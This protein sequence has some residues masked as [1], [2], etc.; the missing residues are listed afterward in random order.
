MN[1]VVCEDAS[2][3][4]VVNVTPQIAFP[5]LNAVGVS[6]TASATGVVSDTLT[7]C[8]GEEVTFTASGG[9]S[10]RFL[11]GGV[12]VQAR[13]TA[14][15][16]ST[17]LLLIND[18]VT[19]E[20]FD[21]VTG[22]CLTETEEII[23]DYSPTPLVGLTS[24][25]IADTFC[26]DDDILFTANS[27]IPNSTYD[28]Y[29]DGFRVF[30]PSTTSTFTAVAGTVEDLDDVSVI[31]TSPAGCSATASLTM[32]ENEI[33]SVGTLTTISPTIC[34]GDVS[35]R[36]VGT[37]ASASGSITY[38]WMNSADNVTYT[39]ITGTNSVSYDPGT[40]TNT[41][42]FKRKT[43]S[44]L[45]GIVCE[46]LSTAIRIDVTATPSATI[47]AN[48]GGI[49]GTNT[50]TIC[51]GAEIVFTG[52]GGVEYEFTID[53]ITQQ[54]RSAQ[55][56]YTTSGLLNNELVQVIAYGATG[57]SNVSDGIRVDI[58]PV[59]VVNLSSDATGNTFC[60]GDVVNFTAISNLPSSTFTFSIGGVPRQT[61][62]TPTF[63]PTDYV[64][65]LNHNDVVQVDVTSMDG[66]TTVASI[67]L[68]ENFINTAG[69]IGAV[70][71]TICAG[72][73]PSAITNTASAVASGTI[74]YQWESGIDTITFTPITGA[75]AATY[76]PT[77][78][79]Q[80]TY[81][82][83]VAISTLNGAICED[84]TLPF[85]IIV[86]PPI[87]GGTVSPTSE[88][89]CSG[90]T[91]SLLTVVGGSTG[92]LLTYQWQ[93]STDGINYTNLATATSA[94]FQPPALN[95]TR[96]YKRITNAVGGGGAASCNDESTAIRITVLDID[97]GALDPDLDQDYCYGILP[98]SLTSSLTGGVIDDAS[99]SNGTVTYVWESSTNNI[100]WTTIATATNNFYNPPA[101]TETT[102][103]RRRAYATLGGNTCEDVTDAIRIGVLPKLDNGAVL[104]DQ[105]ICQIISAAELPD[106][107][108][109]DGAETLSASLSYQW[110]ISND[111]SSWEDIAGQQSETLDFSLGDT[112]LPTVPA[113]YYRA[114]VTYVGDPAPAAI[115][116]T[117]IELLPTAFPLTAGQE[118]SVA[119]NGNNYT[120]TTVTASTIDTVGN[121][122]A[123]SITNND[124]VVNATYN[125]AN[126][127]LTIVP[128]VPGT[129]NVA[130]STGTPDVTLAALI[131]FTTP[132]ID[133]QVLVSGDNGARTPNPNRASCQIYSEVI[134][135]EVFE[136]P[137]L[138]Q[139][140]GD[141]SPQEVCAG[142]TIDP[143]TYVI[144]GGA[145][146]A[147]IRG[148]DA[149]L[150]VTPSGTGTV[151]PDPAI[152]G[153]YEVSGTTTFTISGTVGQTTN[154]NVVTLGS[155]PDCTEINE[156][157]LIRVSPLAQTPDFIRKDVNQPGYEVLQDPGNANIW[158]NN[159][160]CQDR[161]P[162]P[163][164][165]P[166]E[167][168][169]CFVDNTFNQQFVEF[170]WD[171]SPSGAGSMV[172]NNFQETRVEVT[173][174]LTAAA[175][176][177]YTA[178]LTTA[179]GTAVYTVTTTAATN[180]NDAIGQALADLINANAAVSARYDNTNPT[181][182]I[183]VE[184]VT[185]NTP[186]TL[187]VA[188]TAAG[189]SSMFENPITRQITRSG[190]MNWD[191]FFSGEATIR[192]RSLG[193]S[194][195]SAWRDIIVDVVPESVPAV[196]PSDLYPPV[197][198]DT[199]ICSGDTTGPI[200]VC[201]ITAATPDTQF[202]AASNNAGNVNDYESLEWNIS[203][204]QPGVGSL[205]N[206]PG[207]INQ[208]TGIM[209][210]TDGWYGN[211]ELQV[212]PISCTGIVGEWSTITITIGAEDGPILS[213][214]ADQLP[215]CPIPA[216]GFTTVLTTGGESVRWFVNSTN[217]LAT[218]T[219]YVDTPT[220]ELFSPDPDQLTL[221]FR[222][223][224]SGAVI[225]TA[226]PT[227][228]PGNSVNYVIQVP[229][230][231]TITLTSGF[232]SN[233]QPNI[234]EGGSILPITYSIEGA[235]N[236][237]FA[238][239][240]PAGIISFLEV[241]TQISTLTLSTNAAN[242]PAGGRNYAIAINNTN[243][244]YT[245]TG[246]NTLND[247]GIGLRDA[248][249]TATDDFEATWSNPNLM[250]EV[251]PTGR[252]SDSFIIS[253][254]V[255]LTNSVNISA[256]ITAPLE[257]TFTISGTLASTVTPGTYSFDVLT[258]PA[259]TGC[260]SATPSSGSI[261]VSGAAS[262][263]VTGTTNMINSQAICNGANYTNIAPLIEFAITD[264]ANI[265]ESALNPVSL[266]DLGLA[267]NITG[268][269]QFNIVGTVNR[270]VAVATVYS[271][272]L[273]ANGG[274][275]ADE[276][277]NLQIEVQPTPTIT[278]ND[279]LLAN[280]TVCVSETITP[281]RFEVLQP[282]F[283][284]TAT[285][286]A[287]P[288]G[289]TGQMYTQNQIVSFEVIGALPASTSQPSETFTININNT[290][291][292]YTATNTRLND[293]IAAD[294][295]NFLNPLLVG[296]YNVTNAPGS[297][298][299]QI[300]S[301]NPGVAYNVLVS[302]IS[303]DLNLDNVTVVRPPGFYEITGT[304][305]VTINTPQAYTYTLFSSGP[306]CSG[307]ATYSG[308]ITVN[309]I[310]YGIVSGGTGAFGFDEATQTLPLCDSN[311]APNF[312]QYEVYGGALN[313]NVV[314]PTTPSWVTTTFTPGTPGILT[315]SVPNPP[316][317][318][319]TTTQ[320]FNYEIGLIGNIYG[321]TVTPNTVRGTIVVTADDMISH[322]GTSGA[323]IQT[324][325]VNST[326]SPT[327]AL[328]PIEY[329]LDGGA[330]GAYT[331]ISVDGGTTW[332]PG[333]PPGLSLNLTVSNTMLISGVAT[334][335]ATT[336]ASPT[337]VYDYRIITTPAACVSATSSGRITVL[338]QP[339]LSLVS[340]ATSD[341]QTGANG[342]CDGTPIQEIRYRMGGGATNV[343]FTWTGPGSNTLFGSGITA[344]ASGTDFIIS[345]TPTVNV[346]Q[347]TTYNY[348]IETVG[349]SCSPEIVLN[350]T[351]EIKPD[352]T[353]TLIS[354][355][356]TDNQSIC[357]FDDDNTGN[358]T[359]EP[360]IDIEYQLGGGATNATVVGLPAGIGFSLT[361]SNT[362][363]IS[364][365]V[366]ASTTYTAT[367]T[368][369]YPYTITTNGD[370]TVAILNGT[371]TVHSPPVMYLDS[372]AVTANQIGSD[373]V[374]DRV[375]PIQ[376]II[377]QLAGGATNATVSW[378]GVNGVLTGVSAS[379]S[380][381]QIVLSGTPSVNVTQTTF[382][383]Y[384]IVTNNS[385]CLPEVT[386][387]GVIQV[388][389]QDIITLISTPTSDNQEICLFDQDNPGN[390][391][392]EP[393]IDIEYQLDG[394]ATN[395]VVT[396]LPAGIGYSLTA[397][398]TILISGTV[399]AS[400][401]YTA[402]PTRVYPYVITTNGSC[403]QAIANGTI[404]VRSLPVLTL[405]SSPSTTNQTAGD[406]VCN[407]IEPIQNI[408]YTFSGG[409][410]GVSLS[411]VATPGILPGVSGAASG[412]Q[413]VIS[414]TPSANI[415]STTTYYYE[416]A[417]NNSACAPEVV[418][419]GSIE[420][421][422]ADR[423]TLVSS[424]TTDA[425]QICV[426]TGTGTLENI[427]YNL[428]N[429]ATGATVV[430]L[431]PGVGYTVF[432]GQVIISGTV[433]ASASLSSATI[434]P[435]AY[436][437]ETIGCNPAIETGTIDVIPAPEMYLRSGNPNAA[438]I[439]NGDIIS[440]IEYVFNPASGGIPVI[441]WDVT[442]TSFGVPT[443]ASTGG[444]VN[445]L[446]VL[447][448]LT[449]NETIS[450]TTIYNYTVRL[451]G[452][453]DSPVVMSG[454]ITISPVPTIDSQFIIDNDV[455]DVTCNGGIDGSIV[456]PD[457]TTVQFEQRIYGGLLSIQQVDE[458]TFSG[459]PTLGDIVTVGVGGN[460]YSHTVVPTTYGSLNPQTIPQIVSDLAVTIN[461]AIGANVSAA[462][463]VPAT[464]ILRLRADVGGIAL[465]TDL[466]AIPVTTTAL[467]A[468]V[469]TVV[470]NR[471]LN[472]S[473]SWT[474]PNGFTSSSLSIYNLEAGDYYLT[475]DLNGCAETS[476]PITVS[477]P[478]TIVVD[479][480][481]CGGTT[482][483]FEANITGGVPPYSLILEDD[484][485][486]QVGPAI[487][488]NGGQVYS[489]LAVGDDYI[490][491]VLDSSC[492]VAV[493]EPIRIPTQLQFIH[494]DTANQGVTNS[495]CS[496]GTIGNGSIELTRSVG[497][498]FESAFQGGSNQFSYVWTSSSSSG[499]IGSTPN[500]YNL[501]PD[502][503]T[504]TVTDLVLGCSD[505]RQFTVG[506]FP[507][508][509]LE[510]V[511]V[512]GLQENI[513]G[514]S[515]TTISTFTGTATTSTADYVYYLECN[516]DSDAAFT[517]RATGGNS[518][519]T[520]TSEVPT[521]TT[522]S[523][524]G[525]SISIQ[526]GGPGFYRFTLDDVGPNG[527]TC[528]DF[529]TVQVIEPS[530]M[531]I[532]EVQA[533]RVDP[534]CFGE[535]G[536][537]VFDVNGGSPNRGPYTI[538]LNGGQL[539]GTSSSAGDRRIIITG[540][541]TSLYNIIA[542]E[543]F[544][545]D[546]YGCSTPSNISTITFSAAPE[547][548][549]FTTETVDIDCAADTEGSV[550]FERI[551][552]GDF[553]DPNLIQIHIYRDNIDFDLYRNWGADPTFKTIDG[554]TQPG[555][556]SYDILDEQN[557]ELIVG[558][559][560]VIRVVGN[561]DP[562]FVRSIDVEQVGCENDT[563]KIRLNIENIQPPLDIRWFQYTYLTTTTSTAS[564]TTNTT[565]DGWV[566]LTGLN[567]FATVVGLDEGVYRAEISDG[568][569]EN[570]GGA[571][572]TNSIILEE[573]SIEITNFRTIENN[574]AFCDNYSSNFTSD[575]LFSI[576]ESLNRNLG[577][578]SFNITLLTESGS[579][580]NNPTSWD[581]DNDGFI[582]P[583]P[584]GYVYRYPELPADRY[585]LIVEE[586][587]PATLPATSTLVPCS[588]VFFFEIQDY[589]PIE[590]VGQTI[591]ETDICT[592]R[593]E[594]IEG[595][596][597]GGVP[598]II[599][600][601]PT[602]Q[603]EWTYTPNDPTQSPTKFFGRVIENAPPGTY[604]VKI[605]DSNGCFY[606][607]CDINASSEPLDIIVED[608]VTPFTVTAALPNP[609][610]PTELV[611][612][613]SPNCDSGGLDGQIGI[614]L[615]GGLL[616]YQ[617]TWYVEDPT[618]VTPNAIVDPNDPSSRL[619][620][621]RE[622]PN[623][624]N[625]T[626]L[627]GLIPGNY[628]LVITSQ[629]PRVT[630]CAQQNNFLNNNYL[631][632]E[633]IIQVSPNREL[634]IM[635]G[636][637]VD[638]DLCT[639]QQGRLI[640]D[641]FDNNNG[642]LS[643]YYNDILIPNS[644]VVRLSDRSWSVAIVN[645]VDSANFK[646]VNEEGCWITTEINRG[647]GDP[648]FN[649]TSPNF[650][651]SSVILARE[652]ITF[653]NTST[654]PYVTSEWIFGDNTP[655]EIVPTLTDSIIPVRHTYGVSGT[656]F[657]TLRIYNDIGCSEEITKPISVGKGY[658]IMVP[659]VFT[660]NNDLVNDNFRPLFSGFANMTFTVYDYRGNVVY[661]EYVEE[662]DL[663]N[664]QGI[665]ITG[666]DA[667]NAPFSPY[668]IY[669]AY[670][671]LLDGETE[672]EK[673]GTFILIN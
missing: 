315:I 350:G 307:S 51:D 108:T 80:T 272:D 140:N 160:V 209:D 59:P 586:R 47:T 421:R 72:D 270:P 399:A 486:V 320:T 273:I 2:N 78:L 212:R 255:P 613:I 637:Y 364:G 262:I 489:G 412:T 343:G 328:D 151:T 196:D 461:N 545:S 372:P 600:G 516:G 246:S 148:L 673:S 508:L 352:D 632:Y 373:A 128:V 515:T 591:I 17:T 1:S 418:L 96:F 191:P 408:V 393:F 21:A 111:Q 119:I 226:E 172:D 641:I 223:G 580:I 402:S 158:Y 672:I 381:T 390:T 512:G 389:P 321:C 536:T 261:T 599:D 178:S 13:G 122:L 249:N 205:V 316:S 556:Y 63:T 387:S 163:T 41:T 594:R 106:P 85:E 623:Y 12:E 574:P 101:L 663:T 407:Q 33:T 666:W 348:Q 23:I 467:T 331:E 279:P 419:T 360:F 497:G 176:E 14:N 113:T 557:C 162:A 579:A 236:G 245:T 585:T 569:S 11:V 345:G 509:N 243:Y 667:T 30:G 303:A 190:T 355:P 440:P 193:C 519:Y 583:K 403:V 267:L 200:P 368:Q 180:T 426:G 164:T 152:N 478:D 369:V 669:T 626:Y 609:D 404:T 57:C 619:L 452:T 468:T 89:I 665:S 117:S 188:P 535:L 93:E 35:S 651:A 52:A 314:T 48:P 608:V 92:A 480:N 20:I 590:Y 309:P 145:T 538:S 123:Q 268:P 296:N 327:F 98:P 340:S 479:I 282:A 237:V 74:T 305:S 149:G 370:C 154:F 357:L 551:G 216:A 526:D 37:A 607:S 544:I 377:Y 371:I 100:N 638:E 601:L 396:G 453:C 455:T 222:P 257:K 157:Y 269:N 36:L 121:A 477:E 287:F 341:N 335:S 384:E 563:S 139:I 523:N 211:F 278:P 95:A 231:P 517:M 19:V 185:A 210:W 605:T 576:T 313:V 464:N 4:A 170:E 179:S 31:I 612:S 539:V 547:E 69:T 446:F 266:A 500:I 659:N 275:C 232:N 84:V 365:T 181:N 435:Y 476:A 38:E 635:D 520:I 558:G 161:L 662:A 294:I 288:N 596:A 204:P 291:Y 565:V 670:G 555:V 470:D 239:G 129:Y 136:Q 375:A 473:Y 495:Y 349:S 434:T 597:A 447:G 392:A 130:A 560:F 256:P 174:L 53:G 206:N 485:G 306:G 524:L 208:N 456:I 525:G 646:I 297:N 572:L 542:P 308:T 567:G 469:S 363:V 351:I 258:A 653:E 250:I 441:T 156:R 241:T 541:D 527:E 433:Q 224:F 518:N 633:E 219:L 45:N 260:V 362:I 77:A 376:D 147:E 127:I 521:G 604:C 531:T 325:C 514:V 73:A 342:V 143:I 5:E 628:K 253:T 153:W 171:V 281:I 424:P 195:T 99:S 40:L 203:N 532:T 26:S 643:F 112:W 29:V 664:I 406:S 259:A 490:L 177:T 55:T 274:P 436:T 501:P 575:V 671:V 611:K 91:P 76:T 141:P 657:T 578:N 428:E 197:A 361:A 382:Y 169:T 310:T 502:I 559:E 423:L 109:L 510:G 571:L 442:P 248:I 90:D 213:I 584:Q 482:G 319:V 577:S 507:A 658:N 221:D 254:S 187:E 487:L 300:E 271:I 304:P 110:Q 475:V 460:T 214:A 451:E 293:E 530:A 483:S 374:C 656:Y 400:T 286:T 137:T 573:S 394:G 138:T 459:T 634:Y 566:P 324:I 636:P 593:V 292:T 252:P 358:L 366:V 326:P 25:A 622:L 265:V 46:D 642:N 548:I 533:Q 302:D 105:Q 43:I 624:S 39:V 405:T 552:P 34:S 411:W 184:S 425:Q 240:L 630:Q 64:P 102:W 380:G 631:Y 391:F 385:A 629:N 505:T 65:F 617:I 430:G 471:A 668:F 97:A 24:S 79:I 27:N 367:P 655:P 463:A 429:G 415:S 32:F 290:N 230:P 588:E 546:G 640:V 592:G 570:C 234:C 553:R 625:R 220:L 166:T 491:E 621:Y 506:G 353:M 283:G 496:T 465:G 165:T 498:T 339:T 167:F 251:G 318:G 75:T 627:D 247:I 199:P 397:S 276:T 49:T 427:V 83:R 217:G 115:E 277:L 379:S 189:Q 549:N 620:G 529:K 7:I 450:A 606:D 615:E 194:G 537:L 618:V 582:D 118:Y 388:E 225:I 334:A 568:R 114:V 8:P 301:L 228:C 409:A 134:A 312:I 454:A 466:S 650:E 317:L 522:V 67:T 383:N 413:F 493:R 120:T 395:A 346:T 235:E 238:T 146:R 68:I 528:T 504:V 233:I 186:F 42:F 595:Q 131:P 494:W 398:N 135:I 124:V 614:N 242:P 88:V 107:V 386:L 207:T 534:V 289:V 564:T 644:D 298:V 87:V 299:V 218:S 602:Y 420:V 175:G 488:T 285:N 6:D 337:I 82:R 103:F 280:Q 54:A 472:Y 263:S 432:G 347:T 416:V 445:N 344:I 66:C 144:G 410:T 133:M 581:L 443:L 356:T 227:P 540:I 10:Y 183:F 492:A 359:A 201:Q 61:G 499:T 639:G 311:N 589:L 562:L 104:D 125:T 142:G 649:Y 126:N 94:D 18:R 652:E 354:S 338:S 660:P 378:T 603:Y 457:A 449:A 330:T 438:A 71:S 647:I 654:D 86:T 462:T 444:G 50:L 336:A 15:T 22:G 474:G 182:S 645:A 58:L 44:T 229:E 513:L 610:D 28:F 16:Y 322:R 116:R 155:G 511:L 132:G 192:V 448:N 554:F 264:A 598:F 168:F 60:T 431:P 417:T 56:T 401:T 458:I 62:A 422:P 323:E 202:F 81:F 284:L 333:L 561:P 616:P 648:N 661:N 244:V 484:N 332:T 503:Y 3:V 481:A 159:T 295:T 329:E 550:T 437:V 173:Q 70:T 414:G 198:L 543:V 587:L 439:C 215:E 9:Q 150:V